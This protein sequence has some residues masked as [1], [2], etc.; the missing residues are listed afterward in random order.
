MEIVTKYEKCSH[1][2][3]QLADVNERDSVRIRLYAGR[4][5]VTPLR[6][7]RYYGTVC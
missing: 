3:S 5:R 4:H 7:W 1:G 2:N 6:G